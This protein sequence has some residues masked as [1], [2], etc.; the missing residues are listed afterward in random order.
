[1]TTL[2]RFA[3]NTPNVNFVSNGAFD[4]FA[5]TPSLVPGINDK[6]LEP[7]KQLV[8]VDTR[9]YSRVSAAFPIQKELPK[10]SP[11]GYWNI[12]GVNGTAT[13]NPGT[14]ISN[15]GGNIL[16]VTFNQS[17]T[18]ALHQTIELYKA[19]RGQKA[20]LCFS[21]YSITGQVK[22]E[23]EL[24]VD[25]ALVT[26]WAGSSTLFGKYRRVGTFATVS[27]QA[28]N[29]AVK[30]TLT[31]TAGASVGLSGVSLFQSGVSI[32]SAFSPSIPDIALPSG[33][34]LLIEGDVCPAGYA[35]ITSDSRNILLSTG[36]GF[37][38]GSE[39]FE[40]FGGSDTHTHNPEGGNEH[41]IDAPLPPEST[42][43]FSAK[44]YSAVI[45]NPGEVPI[46]AAGINH[47]HLVD[48][49]MTSVPPSFPVRV[50]R[51][52]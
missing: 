13:I 23:A 4:K 10:E 18:I 42:G 49:T 3:A 38:N 34:V 29:I 26:K 17:G 11:I 12:S 44:P 39:D 6:L 21:G 5:Y 14:L 30:F 28:K 48:S 51:K 24:I 27:N 20:T 8:S 45:K 2:N 41:E 33:T 37:I 25:G 36:Q 15:D 22:I 46:V 19:L 1:M 40:R 9:K 52:L 31:A 50:C 7:S 32:L 16:G 47:T 35:S 43:A